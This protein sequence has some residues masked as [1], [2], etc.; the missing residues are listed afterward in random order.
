MEDKARRAHSVPEEIIHYY[1]MGLEATRFSSAAG[2]LEFVR[3]KEII[4]RYLPQ[5]PAVVLDVGGGPGTYAQWLSREGF[6][7]HLIDPIAL[8]GEQAREASRRQPTSPIRSITV[9]DARELAYPDECADLVLLL[10]PLYHLTERPDR[11]LAVREA[12]RV[13]RPRGQLV[14][15]AISRFASTFAGLAQGHLQDSAFLEM[16]RR[17]LNDGQHR[18][19]THEP[20]HFTTSFHHH[21]SELEAEIEEAG[22]CVETLLA[23]EGVAVFLQDLE[24][25]WR[26][27]ARRERIL[28]VLR[29]LEDEPTIMGASAHI[30]AVAT[31]R[32]KPARPSPRRSRT[33]RDR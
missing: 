17:C 6:E 25:Q 30:A 29:W 7:V 12:R 24:Q 32:A 33:Y 4:S 27:S 19:P 21:S 13:L 10:G 14:A 16:M 1:E 9:G 8:H 15:V 23:I 18:N 28:E 2:Q 20:G 31:K 11:L 22:F 26:D 5:A 3:T